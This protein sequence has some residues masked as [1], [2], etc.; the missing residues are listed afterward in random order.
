MGLGGFFDVY[1]R[2]RE[3]GPYLLEL[4]VQKVRISI[5]VNEV[6]G[7]K[8]LNGSSRGMIKIRGKVEMLPP[9]ESDPYR[10]DG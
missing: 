7:N 8:D 2:S 10:F 3:G 1:R 4:M 5:P 9:P 6:A